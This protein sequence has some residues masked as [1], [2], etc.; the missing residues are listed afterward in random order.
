MIQDIQPIVMPAPEDRY[1]V[2]MEVYED[3]IFAVLDATGQE[4]YSSFGQKRFDEF[5]PSQTVSQ[6]M[7]KWE[8]GIEDE[9]ILLTGCLAEDIHPY[10]TVMKRD[11]FNR[12]IFDDKGN[13]VEAPVKLTRSQREYYERRLEK[14]TAQKGKMTFVQYKPN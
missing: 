12:F 13:H 14:L 3:T 10:W 1:R 8:Q 5:V 9:I 11:E 6:M 4:I 7:E 2:F